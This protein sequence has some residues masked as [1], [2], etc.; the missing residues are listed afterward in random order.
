M[1]TKNWNE[2][3]EYAMD[4]AMDFY[5]FFINPKTG[6]IFLASVKE[7]AKAKHNNGLSFPLTL[8]RDAFHSFLHDKTLF[9]E[10]DFLFYGALDKSELN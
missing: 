6:Y 1:P 9:L 7:L 2:Y 5:I 4:N 3:L 8:P 10:T